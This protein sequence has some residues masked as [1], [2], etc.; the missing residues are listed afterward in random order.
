[1]ALGM[2]KT[3]VQLGILILIISYSP[4]I[5]PTIG[6]CRGRELHFCLTFIDFSFLRCY[7]VIYIYFNFDTHIVHK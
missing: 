1:M 2:K 5:R 6:F 7:T 3:N 4:Q